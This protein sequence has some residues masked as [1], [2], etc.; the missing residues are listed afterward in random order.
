M[1]VATVP[2]AC[3]ADMTAGRRS[4]KSFDSR[5][6]YIANHKV[7]LSDKGCAAHYLCGSCG[8]IL[9][10]SNTNI[11]KPKSPFLFFFSFLKAMLGKINRGKPCLI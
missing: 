6:A 7:K 9:S 5:K 3:T 8:A 1:T 10:A 4:T 11:T 2:Q